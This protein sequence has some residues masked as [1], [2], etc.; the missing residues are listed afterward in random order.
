LGVNRK[1]EKTGGN[2]I[3]GANREGEDFASVPHCQRVL[4]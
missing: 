4:H 2:G 3:F 1:K